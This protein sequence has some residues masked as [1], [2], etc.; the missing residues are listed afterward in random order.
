MRR[1]KR[2][3]LALYADIFSEPHFFFHISFCRHRSEHSGRADTQELHG[4][5]RLGFPTLTALL[6][7]TCTYNCMAELIEPQCVRGERGGDGRYVT[8]FITHVANSR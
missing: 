2:V 7:A 5:I 8:Y 3:V 4:C 6:R 1:K